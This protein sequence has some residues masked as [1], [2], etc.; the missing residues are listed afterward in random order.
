[1]NTGKSKLQAWNLARRLSIVNLRCRM[2]YS[3]HSSLRSYLQYLKWKECSLKTTLVQG[4]L[5][6]Y[7]VKD[8]LEKHC[9]ALKRC[10]GKDDRGIDLLG[11]FPLDGITKAKVAV[12]C[13]SN[14][15][16]I[17]PRYVREL[18]G[19]LSWCPSDTLGILACLSNFTSASLKAVQVSERPL[20]VCRIF[21][22][23]RSSYMFQFAWNSA[24]SIIFN[25]ISVRQLHNSNMFLDTS[26]KASLFS[27]KIIS[28][29]LCSSAPFEHCPTPVG[30]FYK[31]KQ[32]SQFA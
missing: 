13:K 7:L 11:K 29:V 19:S 28:T 27:D 30:L 2:L 24:A 22:N 1:M 9:F 16:A 26:E 10:G 32:I 18:E 4:T 6:E 17:G 21:V 3:D 12:S 8:I 31:N 14:K 25:D 20:A 23:H 15:G 5:F